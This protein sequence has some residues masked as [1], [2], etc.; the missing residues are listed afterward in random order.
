MSVRS[1]SARFN[2]EDPFQMQD[3]LSEEERLVRDT[4]RQYAQEQLLPR[5]DRK[6]VV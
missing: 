2:W 1:D 6:S 3:L 5:V 4:A